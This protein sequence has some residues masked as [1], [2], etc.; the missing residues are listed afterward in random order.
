[1]KMNMNMN[2]I[3]E[4]EHEHEHD[5][6][7]ICLHRGA[8]GWTPTGVVWDHLAGGSRGSTIQQWGPQWGVGLLV[9]W[10]IV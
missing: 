10:G 7:P 3:N 4:H 6:E 1:M 2:M 9:G 8:S 5:V